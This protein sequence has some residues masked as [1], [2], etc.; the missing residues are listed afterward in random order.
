[1]HRRATFLAAL[2]SSVSACE[3][4]PDGA[5]QGGGGS[6]AE[7]NTGASAPTPTTGGAES[8]A[9]AGGGGNSG[10]GGTNGSGGSGDHLNEPAGFEPLCHML[11]D[12]FPA[13][14]VPAGTWTEMPG[15]LGSW[16]NVYPYAD[17]VG[18]P[19]FLYLTEDPTTPVNGPK[20]LRTAWNSGYAVP[21]SAPAWFG[22]WKSQAPDQYGKVYLSWWQKLDGPTFETNC[23]FTKWGFIGSARSTN[24]TASE[25]YLG[26]RTDGTTQCDPTSNTYTD[27]NLRLAI[28][29]QGLDDNGWRADAV[30]GPPQITVGLW[31][32]IE[33]LLETNEILPACPEAGPLGCQQDGADGKA[34]FWVDGELVFAPSGIPFRNQRYQNKFFYWQW[35]PVFGGGG[36]TGPKGENYAKF[37]DFY[38]SASP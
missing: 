26:M 31:H 38:I 4:P 5:Q 30:E 23:V 27:T 17:G 19:N 16:W 22:C 11:G 24:E 14:N 36:G 34:T 1:M 18:D 2:L 15:W 33:L 6:G 21:G 32:H 3:Q 13:F 10:V 35:M 7:D 28:V 12:Q 20:V 8:T 25:I 29:T 37:S 9:G